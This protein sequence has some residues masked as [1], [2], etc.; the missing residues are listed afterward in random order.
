MHLRAGQPTPHLS[1]RIPGVSE[2]KNVTLES[3]YADR[4][5][6]LP[7]LAAELVM[8]N[9]DIILTNTVFANVY[10]EMTTAAFN[11]FSSIQLKIRMK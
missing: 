11:W 2:G 7:A 8:S 9:V 10:K 6:Q 5:D 3:R 4:E 1:H